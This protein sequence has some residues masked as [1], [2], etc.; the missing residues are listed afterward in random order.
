MDLE[1]PIPLPSWKRYEY[2]VMEKHRSTYG[3]ITYHWSNIPE[4]LLFECGFIN[5]INDTKSMRERRLADKRDGIVNS[6]QEYGLDGIAYEVLDDKTGV[7]RFYGIQCKNYAEGAYLR[8][9]DIATFLS[10][11]FLRLRSKC[12]DTK[13]YLYHSCR[14]ES[15]LAKDL[16]CSGDLIVP[17]HYENIGTYEEVEEKKSEVEEDLEAEELRYYQKEAVE[18]L[19]E[20]WDGIGLLNL[21]CGTGKTTVVGHYLRDMV[22]EGKVDRIFVFSPLRVLAK[23]NLNR[24][25]NYI[26]DGFKRVLVDG[27]EDG[28][29]D[30]TGVLESIAEGKVLISSTYYSAKDVIGT[31][32]KTDED[33]SEGSAGSEEEEVEEVEK[34]MSSEFDGSMEEYISNEYTENSIVIVDE[35]HNVDDELV[36]VL[37]KFKRVLLLTATPTIHLYERITCHT[38]YNYS[39]SQ[40]IKDKYVCDYKIYLPHI[41]YNEIPLEFKE[42]DKETTAKVLYLINGMLKNGS[43]RCIVY[44][45]SV[46]DC[47]TFNT[48][49][50]KVMDEYHGLPY[51][52]NHITNKVSSMDRENILREFDGEED[53]EDRFYVLSSVRIL[54]EGVDFVKCDAVF[55]D[56]SVY[57]SGDIRHIQR[58]CRS[59][60]IDSNNP[61]KVS[62]CYLWCDDKLNSLVPF[63]NGIKEVDGEYHKKISALNMGYERNYEVKI[64]EDMGDLSKKITTYMTIGTVNVEDK[65]MERAIGIVTRAKEREKKGLNLMP[66]YHSHWRS[67]DSVVQ[68]EVRDTQVIAD[69]RKAIRMKIDYTLS[70]KVIE[71]LNQELPQW[72]VLIDYEEEAMKHAIKIYERACERR[73]IGGNYYPSVSAKVSKQERDDRIKLTYWHNALNKKSNSDSRAICPDKVRVF[74]SEKF[75]EW[76]EPKDSDSYH[77]KKAIALIERAKIRASKGLNFIPLRKHNTKNDSPELHMEHFDS[78]QLSEWKKSY[79]HLAKG[80]DHYYVEG[81]KK[82]GKKVR[83]ICPLK[84]QE[85]LNQ[86]FPGWNIENE[87]ELKELQA[88][89]QLV[90]RCMLRK[91]KGMRTLPRHVNNIPKEKRTEDERQ[92]A[93]DATKLSELKIK[94]KNHT[95]GIKKGRY[96]QSVY[97]YLDENIP[98]WNVSHCPKS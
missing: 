77:C 35:A 92:E 49:F 58:M 42:Y 85:L 53:R 47:L 37:K 74:L 46:A 43:R 8:A 61:M 69:W 12:M 60:R 27:D 73:D 23:Q 63:M 4:D 36:E 89:E 17:I 16:K 97:D 78:V 95:N 5:E 81:G 83:Y 29:R 24:I 6:V 7:K 50:S 55:M 52:V 66:K 34:D 18:A 13:G 71:Y 94:Y 57:N 64:K 38:L 19:K 72:T 3:H 26:G 82:K 59:N 9:K 41:D 15:R 48:I 40:A 96:F 87:Y 54:D 33:S 93:V 80:I 22:K 44:M 98:G 1:E 45:P 30:V 67:M 88:V 76:N 70:P 90:N 56:G 62:S 79:L 2:D 32:F 31:I 65:Q 28:T 14:L 10:V 91:E 25:G 51:W 68:E 84:V 20:E 75:P 86:Y 39:L 21:P 11:T